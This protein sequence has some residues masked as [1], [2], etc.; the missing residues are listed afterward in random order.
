MDRTAATWEYR[1]L[2]FP[3]GTTREDTRVLLTGAAESER[4]ELD[5]LRLYPDGRRHVRLRRRVYRM[6]RT[7]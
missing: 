7:A 3:R 5:R 2:S 1:D 6:M 4:W